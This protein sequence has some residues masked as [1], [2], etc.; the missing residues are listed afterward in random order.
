LSKKGVIT[1]QIPTLFGMLGYLW[2]YL[3]LIGEKIDIWHIFLLNAIM[4]FFIMTIP[5]DGGMIFDEVHYVKATEAILQGIAANAEHPPLVKLIIGLFIKVFGDYWFSWRMPIILFSIWIPY[6]IYRIVIDLVGD[7]KKALFAAAFSCFDIILFIHGNIYMLEMPALVLAMFSAMW[8]I[9]KGYIKSAIAMGLAC[10]CNEK[11]VFP[12]VG[13]GIYQLWISSRKTRLTILSGKKFLGYL[14]I[15]AIIG[16]G[17][18]WVSDVIW[19]PST[20]TS[21]N[22]I[23]QEIVYIDGQ[24]N[25]QTTTTTTYTKFDYQYITDPI[26]HLLFMFGYYTGLS[27]NIPQIAETYRP[28]WSWIGPWGPNW[29]HG[30]AYLSTSVSTGE[31]SYMIIDYRG[32][33]TYSIWWMTIPLFIIGLFFFK[34]KEMKF[35]MAWII[36]TYGPWLIWDGIRQNIPFNHYFM[37]AA[38]GC[39]IGIPIFWG[40]VLPKYQYQATAVHL[41]ITIAFFFWYFPICFFR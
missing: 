32:Q 33:T 30:P 17:G 9:E 10:L 14:T 37:S 18:L 38:I 19:R 1:V 5:S 26:H 23:S 25:P 20:S 12:L 13:L 3:S 31:K 34:T 36:G 41:A 39:C 24:G 27:N 4:R 2:K 6:I 11:A 21:A 15:C 28:A 29:D 22:V 40:R 35:V 8:F 16:F 7:R